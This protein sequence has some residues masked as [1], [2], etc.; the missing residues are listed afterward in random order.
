[1][2]ALAG[3]MLPGLDGAKLSHSADGCKC[4]RLR[5]TNFENQLSKE[6]RNPNDE[7]PQAAHVLIYDI[8]VFA[9]L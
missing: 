9:F 3:W 4:V 1:M 8:W 6:A 2:T 7:I 5:M